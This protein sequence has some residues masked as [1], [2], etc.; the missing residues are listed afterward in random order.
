MTSVAP[1]SGDEALDAMTRALVDAARPS[2]IILFGSRA[3]GEARPDSDY[4]LVVELEYESSDYS[5]MLGRL[6]SAAT[7]LSR[8]ISVDVMIRRPGQIEARRDDPGYM[9]WDIARHGIVLYPPGLSS[10]VLRPK[11]APANRV[12]EHE[13]YESIKD[14]LE[15][16]DQDFRASELTLAAGESAAWGAAG[17]H[18]QQLAEKYLKILLVQAG[19]HPPKFR[20]LDELIREVR[21]AGYDFPPFATECALLNPY[22]VAIRYPEQAPLPSEEE[23]RRVIDAAQR[24]V[25]AARARLEI[26]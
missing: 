8:G 24:I 12:R 22:A 4:D 26:R 5:P 7:A 10:E 13:P 14:W 18:A 20:A 25:A 1:H 16:A 3:R 19:V 11:S 21:I 15:R 23:G 17:F 9:D 6:T 2:R